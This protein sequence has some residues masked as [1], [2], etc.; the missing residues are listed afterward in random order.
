MKL[1]HE[2]KKMKHHDA[3]LFYS[4]NDSV[5]FYVPKGYLTPEIVEMYIA[6]MSERKV[7]ALW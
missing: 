3:I 6:L 7:Y 1:H 4:Y 2:I 5:E